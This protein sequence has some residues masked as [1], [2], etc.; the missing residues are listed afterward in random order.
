MITN[1]MYIAANS[2]GMKAKK[3]DYNGAKKMRRLRS[4]KMS[5][6][7]AIEKIANEN[8]KSIGE[9]TVC[10]GEDASPWKDSS[11]R[12]VPENIDAFL[13]ATNMPIHKIV[14][15]A[16]LSFGNLQKY[17][18]G[19]TKPNIVTVQKLADFWNVEVADMFLPVK[20]WNVEHVK[21]R[22]KN[23]DKVD[24]KVISEHGQNSKITNKCWVSKNLWDIMVSRGVMDVEKEHEIAMKKIN[25]S[26]EY[27]Y[28]YARS[29]GVA[30]GDLLVKPGVQTEWYRDTSLSYLQEN[31]Q[32]AFN[33]SGIRPY[34][35]TTNIYK[36]MEG[37]I[38]PSL[39]MLQEIADILDMEIGDLLLPTDGIG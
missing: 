12:Y 33:E 7:C 35:V 36:Y 11:S 17:R 32:N 9:M 34:K 13:D 25:R 37:D 24:R 2:K 38:Y 4:G 15:S 39:K 23:E 10:P 30:I 18:K 8:G 3:G 28:R 5:Q 16:G 1:I 29:Y 14:V 6:I 20:S 27:M 26:L 22:K 21:M 19:Q 31:M